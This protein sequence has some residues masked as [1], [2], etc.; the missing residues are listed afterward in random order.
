VEEEEPDVYEIELKMYDPLAK[1]PFYKNRRFRC[2]ST[3]IVCLVL[4]AIIAAIAFS[5]KKGGETI[6]ITL[7]P[8][9]FPSMA[10]T[11]TRETAVRGE[12][13]RVIGDIINE[14]GTVFEKALDWILYDDDM[15]LNEFS[16]N[17]IQRY[18]LALFYYQ[19]SQEGEWISCNPPKTGENST[20]EFLEMERNTDDNSR[21]YTP[22]ED[23]Q[24]RWLSEKHELNGQK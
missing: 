14:P 22:R 6:I 17:L 11:T 10:P 12:L 24:V 13:A 3:L 18:T 16:E 5:A 7:S 4:G 15:Q 1:P 8:S 20:C 23:L 21:F 9:A 19:T 2:Y